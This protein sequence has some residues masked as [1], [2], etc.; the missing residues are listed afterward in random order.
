MSILLFCL[1]LTAVMHVMMA[2][3]RGSKALGGRAINSTLPLQGRTFV[4]GDILKLRTLV[5]W[6]VSLVGFTPDIAK[7]KQVNKH[8]S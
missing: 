3:Q 1:P 6:L 2:V 7:C 8:N 5:L 4:S